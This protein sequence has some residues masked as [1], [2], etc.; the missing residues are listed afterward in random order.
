VKIAFFVSDI[1]TEKPDYTTTRLAM[2]AAE[3]GHDTF[4]LDLDAISF[5]S[6]DAMRVW[7]REVPPD[8]EIPYDSFVETIREKAES[9]RIR[10]DELDVLMLRQEPELDVVDRPW[11]QS[12]GIAFGEMAAQ[13]GV[14]VLNDPMGFARAINKLYLH[15]FPPE[16]QPRTLIT[17]NPDE[18]KE[19][20]AALGGNAVIKPLQSGK[21]ENVFLVKAD[22]DANLNQMVEVVQKE[23]YIVV[24]EYI[25]EAGAGDVRLMMMNAKPL[26]VDGR[27]AA[28]FRRSP[29]DDLR[30]NISSGG[31]AEAAEVDDRLLRIAKLV[32]PKLRRDGMFLVGLDIAGDKLIE[33]NGTSP[34]TLHSSQWTTGVDFAPSV[35]EALEHKL[36]LRGE[37]PELT[38]AEVATL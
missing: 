12:L 37:K 13:R 31:S 11:S 38:N 20:I 29:D 33:I 36:K 32:E 21:G 6:D 34:G 27:V 4:Y 2:A 18:A 23:G 15:D 7:A 8:T 28:V 30:S 19:F 25:V 17:R 10:V 5:V 9:T 26:E 3:A 35:I 1:T 22:E 16:I 24:Q 14:I